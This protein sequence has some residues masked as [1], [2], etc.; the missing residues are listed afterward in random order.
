MS[1]KKYN[2]PVYAMVDLST[3]KIEQFPI[4]EDYFKKFM[5][6]KTLAARLLL[7]LMPSGLDPL[8]PGAVIIINTGPL[9]GTGA[10]SSSRFNVSFKNVLTGGIASSNCGGTFGFMM[11]RAGYDGLIIKGKAANPC[12]IEI[13]DSDISVKGAE[14]LWGLDTE[15][16][17]EKLPA[18]YG[19]LVIGPAG[20]NLVRYASAASG[21]RMA[22]RCGIGAA[23][24]SKN[25]KALSAY[26]TRGLELY[27]PKKF[28]RF[29]KK[30]VAFLRNHPMTCDALPHY[31]SMGLV[32]K[33]NASNALPTHNFKFG[34][35]ENADKVS[36][37]TLAETL[38]VRNSG[39]VS[40]PIR[41]ERRV[42]KDG[43]E[44][45]GPE[46]ETA[47]FFGPN[48]EAQDLQAIID[49]N[50]ACDLL[51]M[52]TISAASTIA[53]AMEL[54]ERG[55]TDKNIPDFGVKFGDVKNLKEVLEKIARREGVYSDLADGSKRMSEKY[56]GGEFAMH[57]KG[58]E[59][60]SYEPRRS[61]GMG[62]GYAVSNRGGCHLNGGYLALIESVG[63]ISAKPTSPASK[64]ELTVFFQDTLEAVSAA[65]CCLF[66]GQTFIPS[67]L[68]RLGPNHF[69]TRMMGWIFSIAGLPIRVMLS[70]KPFLRFNTLYLL[71]HAEAIRLATGLP[72]YTGPFL[73]MGERSYNLERLFNLREGLGPANDSL[74]DRLT[75][76]PQKPEDPS[77]VVPLGK[78][79]PVYYK[80][81]GWGKD[82]T[83]SS[84]KLKSLGIRVQA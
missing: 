57:S 53:F 37:E 77:T 19:K 27:N 2:L 69:I 36:G 84:R 5:G 11:K 54:S 81:R 14:E 17:Q 22:G 45:K 59:M 67:F 51:G 79:L 7:D 55:S 12:R 49:L 38:L 33:A 8:D 70:M 23:L 43:T 20:E 61:V 63:V 76:T 40:C 30:W 65:G 21:E 32:N 15:K 73:Q 26:G 1:A 35:Y 46:Y 39:C 44:I 47:G 10:P 28:S 80:V 16:T 41:C 60:A 42:M 58:L 74:P 9:C 50:Y 3:G 66:S 72:M 29:I 34:F 64:G 83:P 71:P 52:D 18:H 56:G 68:F 82:G 4:S 13:V 6:G 75:K 25:I 78:M 62:L 24:G 31:G 48:M